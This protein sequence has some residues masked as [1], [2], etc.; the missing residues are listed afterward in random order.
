MALTNARLVEEIRRASQ[1]KSEFL[2]TMSHELRTPLNAVLGYADMA[3]DPDASLDDRTGYLAQIRR[4]GARLLELVEHTLEIGRIESGHGEP[5]L[6]RVWLP[7]LWATL[8]QTHTRLH[9]GGPVALDWA[10]TAPDVTLRTDAR[11]LTVA[12]RH[13]VD[14]ALKFTDA[15]RVRV[16]A[17]A[18]DASVAVTVQ[19]TG[20][21]IRAEDHALIFEMFRQADGS[22]TRRHGGT[23]LGLYLVRRFVHQLG[24]TVELDSAPGRGSCFTL[25][26]PRTHTLRLAR[27]AA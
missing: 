20:A 19:D 21:G 17:T 12:I 18:D 23:G 26:L 3:G 15:G 11:K 9:L 6:E 5:D 24:G 27:R 22:E 7:D 25:R 14:N 1:V 10:A 4:A 2:S 13:L 8:R 16:T